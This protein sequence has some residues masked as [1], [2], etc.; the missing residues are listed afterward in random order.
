MRLF[1]DNAQPPLLASSHIR[2]SLLGKIRRMIWIIVST[3]VIGYV[4]ICLLLLVFQARLIFFPFKDM[5][6][7][8]KDLGLSYEDV[9]L[10]AVDGPRL[11]AWFVPAEN[12][13]G[14]ILFCHGNAGNISHC[15][16]LLSTLNGMGYSALFFDYRQFGRSEGTLSEQGT[17][18]DARA[19]WDYLVKERGIPAGK[20]AVFGW[21]LG[22]AVAAQLAAS[23][24]PDQQ[25]GAVVLSSAFS[26]LGDMA[27]RHYPLFPA[28]LLLR[29]EYPTAANAAKITRPT[30]VIHSVDDEIVPFDHAR[31]IFDAVTAEKSFLKTSG[32][33]NDDFGLGG[34]QNV[35]A[36]R[37]FLDTS[38]G[39][40][41]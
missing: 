33:H 13:K 11:H 18:H 16:S 17:Y 35:D 25:P 2:L 31:K 24:P 29:F 9:W 1:P 36:L 5:E 38:C 30:L 26:S 40:A 32:G 3:L 34:S 7:T 39:A 22:G 19:A 10:R 6:V 4:A 21:S 14:I 20:I 12:A 41:P 37:R 15:V 28:R 8:P 27:S 23:L